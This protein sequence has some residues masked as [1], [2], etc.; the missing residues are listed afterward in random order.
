MDR[1]VS[2]YLQEGFNCCLLRNSEENEAM[3]LTLPTGNT[4]RQ[5]SQ[6]EQELT[7]NV[8]FYICVGCAGTG[9]YEGWK[10]D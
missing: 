4:T 3:Q 6:R 8:T 7:V 2:C 10:L 9:E 1:D 5:T